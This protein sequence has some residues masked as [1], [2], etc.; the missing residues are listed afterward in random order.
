MIELHMQTV[1]TYVHISCYD[2]GTEIAIAILMHKLQNTCCTETHVTLQS[3]LLYLEY[4]ASAL[5][6]QEEKIATYA[7]VTTSST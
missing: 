6:C 1:P 2:D 4:M 5:E 3:W 7:Y